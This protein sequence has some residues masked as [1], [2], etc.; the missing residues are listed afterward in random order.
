MLCSSTKVCDRKMKLSTKEILFILIGGPLLLFLLAMIDVPLVYWLPEV[1][2]PEPLQYFSIID[3]I[4]QSGT[5]I[6][7]GVVFGVL[8]VVLYKFWRA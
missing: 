8:L 5:S 4:A 7:I 6:L 2:I 1:V 3:I